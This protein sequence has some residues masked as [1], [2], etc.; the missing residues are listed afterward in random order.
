MTA[1]TMLGDA[2]S[3]LSGGHAEPT[4]A[5]FDRQLSYDV[6]FSSRRSNHRQSTIDNRRLAIG[7]L[8][9][10]ASRPVHWTE[11]TRI[12]SMRSSRATLRTS[13]LFAAARANPAPSNPHSR[14]GQA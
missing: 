3:Q 7:R 11:C 1:E 2:H 9:P 6:H 8:S 4:F 13:P 5:F 12:H 14:R 10:F